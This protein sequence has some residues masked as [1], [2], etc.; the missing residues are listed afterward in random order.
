QH[1]GPT[2]PLP[3]PMTRPGIQRW[4]QGQPAVL[5]ANPTAHSGKA[6]EWIRHARACLDEVQI[7]HRFVP[8]EPDGATI[9][10]VTEAIDTGGA[11]L[12]I[13]M[14][15]DGTFAEVA[16]G[17]LGSQHAAEVAM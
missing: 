12:V 8:T 14:G 11:R 3:Q 9:E 13:Y 2:V 16:K 17:I 1:A 6:A 5:V 15:G 4:T 7:A 10:R